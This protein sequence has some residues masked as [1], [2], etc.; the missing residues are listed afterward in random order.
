MMTMMLVM[1]F[2]ILPDLF[3]HAH[4]ENK[5]CRDNKAKDEKDH[6]V[7]LVVTSLLKRSEKDS[8]LM[9]YYKYLVP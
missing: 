4:A 9:I 5:H 6:R 3:P 2:P 7:C 1:M 8:P